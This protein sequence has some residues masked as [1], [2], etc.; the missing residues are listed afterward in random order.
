M[1]CDLLLGQ[2]Q[3]AAGG[4]AD[5]LQ[6]EVDV[7]DHLGDGMLD[8]DAGV[9]LDEVELAVLVEELDGADAEIFHLLHRLGHGQPDLLARAAASSAG[10]GPSSQTFWWRRCSEQSRSPRWI[11][12]PRPSPST[13]ISMWR[14]F[15]QVFFEIDRGVAEGGFGLVGGGR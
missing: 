3:V 4:D 1:I 15:W 10:E 12:P 2:R 6:H 9:H 11:A 8:L 13:W 14:G 5:L 7:G